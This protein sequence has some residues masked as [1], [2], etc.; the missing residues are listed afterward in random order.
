M[1]V[2]IAVWAVARGPILNPPGAH[3]EAAKSH[4]STVVAKVW[5]GDSSN[6]LDVADTNGRMVAHTDWSTGNIAVLN[7]ESGRFR[8]LTD[9]GGWARSSEYGQSPVLSPDGSQI[10]Y[11][12]FN[13]PGATQEY[14]LHLI[15]V[16][17]GEAQVLYSNPEVGY[18]HPFDWTADGEEILVAVARPDRSNQ[19]GFVS[20]KD[21]TLRILKNLEWRWPGNVSLSPDGR[22]IV[23][24]VRPELNRTDE[25]IFLIAA[26]G[27]SE[28]PLVAAPSRDFVP[29]WRPNGRGVL[30]YS[31]RN[32]DTAA[33]T[34][35]IKD[36]RPHGVPQL[37]REGVGK[38]RPLGWSESGEFYYGLATGRNGL[39]VVEA[40]FDESRFV[41]EPRL[42]QERLG[43]SRGVPRWS[44]DGRQLAY[45]LGSPGSFDEQGIAIRDLETGAESA[46]YPQLAGWATNQVW[47]PSGDAF[48]VKGS[49]LKGRS[50]LFRIES[51][52][53]YAKLIARPAAGDAAS[54]PCA[55]P[56][57][58]RDAHTVVCTALMK[59]AFEIYAFDFD[60]G[61]KTL[62]HREE[63]RGP[64]TRVSPDG[65]WVAFTKRLDKGQS[66][67][68]KVSV[69]GGEPV[70]LYTSSSEA[71]RVYEWTP[72]SRRILI[73]EQDGS[74]YQVDADG[75]G[76]RKM[77]GNFGNGVLHFF[78]FHPDGRQA[79]VRISE[80]GGSIW[81]MQLHAG[82]E[83]TE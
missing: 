13:G 48:L 44:P 40:D 75:K 37:V 36:G 51:G 74:L 49:D 18:I 73:G 77:D 60:T 17:G 46:I 11:A 66:Q 25:D 1:A 33:W 76:A 4:G 22:H 68:M 52:S 56:G 47:Y 53:G 58:A 45:V 55:H 43:R 38:T 21:G 61:N 64:A 7:L 28:I 31:N 50:G 23:Y 12:W 81:S 80:E 71:I 8:N 9:T 79:V 20:V 15:P 35:E 78:D 59:D 16:D 19:I 6:P 3:V 69:D 82:E 30:F 10:T 24:D 29:Y 34:I 62:I 27:S 32:Y 2:G 57:F 83:A 5:E 72:D 70:E 42:L 41:G 67:L 54:N 63:G 14:E 39:Y 65:H 26:D